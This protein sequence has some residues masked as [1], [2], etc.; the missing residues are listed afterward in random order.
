M[1]TSQLMNNFFPQ[2]ADVLFSQYMG[3]KPDKFEIKFWTAADTESK[4][5]LNAFPYLGNDEFRQVNRPLST[6]VVLRLMEPFT[7]KGRNVTTDNFFTS[8]QLAEHL[9]AKNTSIV[10]PMNKARREI[11]SQMKSWK[12]QLY[13]TLLLKNKGTTLAK[14]QSKKNKTVFILSSLHRT[15][16]IGDGQKKKPETVVYY[17]ATTFGVDVLDQMARNYSARCPSRRWP[18]RVFYDILDLPSINAWILYSEV[19]EELAYSLKNLELAESAEDSDEILEGES[20]TPNKKRKQCQIHLCKNNKTV[21]TC[22][23]CEKYKCGKC[24]AVTKQ[25]V[26]CKLCKK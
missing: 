15:V 8:L 13:D 26:F 5:M 16:S 11:P 22:K 18:G 25:I 10:G 12:G 14:P 7:G 2:N 4:Y 20:R 6:H 23:K 9:K 1:R 17:N 21:M 3:N 24:T 19:T